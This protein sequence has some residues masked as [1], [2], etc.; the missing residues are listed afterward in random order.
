[1]SGWTVA[2]LTA[3]G[4]HA[5]FQAT[6]T[7]LVYPALA[8][9]RAEDFAAAHDAHSRRITPLVAVVYGV[10]VVASAGAL[11]QSPGSTGVRLAATGTAGAVLVTAAVAA[12]TH[13]HL[14]R[15]RTPQLVAR[16]LVADRVRLGC[17]VLALAGAVAAARARP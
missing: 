13:G 10:A 5:G 16:L 9:V 12:P 17:A 2:L 15:R 3:T 6:V 1:M 11:R 8:G 4:A 7:G 14:G